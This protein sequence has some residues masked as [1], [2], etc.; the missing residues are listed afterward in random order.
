[1][2]SDG[3]RHGGVQEK[4]ERDRKRGFMKPSGAGYGFWEPR[5]WGNPPYQ[6]Y[7]ERRAPKTATSRV[8]TKARVDPA[9]QECRTS[10]T[11]ESNAED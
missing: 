8:V 1:M 10:D 11:P 3:G 6:F 2:N 5:M 7:A 9:E 4:I